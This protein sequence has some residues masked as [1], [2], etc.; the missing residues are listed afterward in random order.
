M[1]KSHGATLG[2]VILAALLL[3]PGTTDNPEPKS[4]FNRASA[5]AS[6]RGAAV[7]GDGPWVASCEFWAP[8]R[9]APQ[10]TASPSTVAFGSKTSSGSLSVR[11]TVSKEKADCVGESGKWGIPVARHFVGLAAKPAITAIIATVPDP[12]RTNL[13]VQFDW[14]IDAMLDAAADNGYMST[15]YWL[16]WDESAGAGEE[17]KPTTGSGLGEQERKPGL[18]ILKPIHKDNR[19]GDLR[20]A[21]YLFLVAETPTSGINGYEMERAFKYENEL[22]S[23]TDL[24]RSLKE[25]GH[26][27]DIIGPIYSASA[28]PLRRFLDYRLETKTDL[29]KHTF[30]ELKGATTSNIAADQLNGMTPAVA[31]NGALPPVAPCSSSPQ[32]VQ[33]VD[34]QST[35]SV[36]TVHYQSFDENSNFIQACIVEL[37]HESN[38]RYTRIALLIEDGTTLGESSSKAEEPTP[39]VDSGTNSNSK[40]NE[41]KPE[42]TDPIVIRFPREIS[43]LRNAETDEPPRL[44][45]APP[46]PYLHLSLKDTNAYDGVPHF[47]RPDTPL[48]QESEVMG[49]VRQL[50][51]YRAQYVL[52]QATNPLD[53]LYLA[54]TLHRTLPNAR[55]AFD[56]PN[57][58]FVREIDDQPLIGSIA[59]GSYHLIGLG[60]PL[61]PGYG[62]RAFA[63]LEAIAYY[64]AASDT[65][66]SG[67]SHTLR[68]VGYVNNLR[69]SDDPVSPPLWMSVIG[70]D[71]YYPLGIVNPKATGRESI[72]PQIRKDSLE[73][74]PQ[75][76]LPVYPSLAWSFLCFFI[77]LLCTLHIAALYWAE[78]WSPATRDLSLKENDQPYRRSLYIRVGAVMLWSAAAVTAMPI[79]SAWSIIDLRPAGLL[80]G[81]STFLAGFAVMGMTYCKTHPYLKEGPPSSPGPASAKRGQV[82][83]RYYRIFS[84]TT[85]I[86]CF[87]IPG[88]W[89]LLCIN[90]SIFRPGSGAGTFFA[91]RCLHPQS[92]V[93]P[94]VPIVLLLAAWYS[95]S[96]SQA[97]RLRFS[98]CNRPMLPGRFNPKTSNPGA[99]TTYSLY[100]SDE[101][102]QEDDKVWT[103]CLY[104]NITSLL[105]TREV[106]LRFF[107]QKDHPANSATS[108]PSIVADWALMLG[109]LLSFGLFVFLPMMHSLDRLFLVRHWLSPFEY[110][111]RA[112]F[113]P[114]LVVAVTGC[115]RLV[116]VWSAL[117]RG[118]LDSMENSPLR[119]A[120]D[121]LK[122]SGWKSMFRQ[123]GLREQWR[124]MAR[125]TESARQLVANA[126]LKAYSNNLTGTIQPLQPVYDSME[127][128]IRA[129]MAYLG[130]KSI[131]RTAPG[132][133]WRDGDICGTD[134]SVARSDDRIGLR[135]MHA[136]ETNY[137][138]FAQVLLEYTLIPRWK[139]D[140]RG[141]VQSEVTSESHMVHSKGVG[142]EKNHDI[143]TSDE[144]IPYCVQ[145][146]EEFVAIRYVAIIRTVMVNL[147][148]LMTFVSIAFVLAIVAWNSY[149]FEPRDL[150]NWLFTI[151]L[152]VLGL[153]IVVVFAQMYRDPVLSRITDKRPNE[154]GWDFYFRV[155]SFGAVPLLTWLAYNYPQIGATLYQ[156]FQPGVGG[157]K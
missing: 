43:M 104:R 68:L 49:I 10:E 57:S 145:L 118:L 6:L 17:N 98:D 74:T 83:A 139:L 39:N 29:P 24:H 37:I 30:I 81:V 131:D 58:L 86:A 114:L 121:R 101:D 70:S 36:D 69:P 99:L 88:A 120:F 156:V 110:L 130:S 90:G 21:V 67:R 41:S 143:E 152:V 87:V 135:L 34:P 79:L 63:G 46:S 27:L 108:T 154:L 142:G 55:L 62:G 44:G 2:T 77:D 91:Y 149:P 116:F 8:E 122:G 78:Y 133:A 28:A 53:Q 4:T 107:R 1:E 137:A 138:E 5:P 61:T 26:E 144:G 92:G 127:H 76:R 111:L 97:L 19:L 38:V 9:L 155:L 113:F 66:W 105:I 31:L 14:T 22:A 136:I 47:S 65:F 3:R 64:N 80:V 103:G 112:L 151:L 140:C 123:S 148:Y 106:I 73:L 134:S 42:S 52:I 12:I 129:L 45:V 132:M 50:E 32:L 117:R 119:F 89:A 109:Y 126:D 51:R 48:I 125:S 102:M 85:W 35:Q 93:S 96:I 13:A 124:D 82:D 128:N 56:G 15:Y 95:W 54:R 141:F 40:T 150:V 84:S 94:L 18:I 72:L 157:A 115:L 59:Y 71:G 153:C 20:S 60:N 75:P 100:V 23:I 146:A 16:P 25:G 7:S 33:S 147:R 11:A